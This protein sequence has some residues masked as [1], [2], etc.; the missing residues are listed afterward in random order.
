[1]TNS[2]RLTDLLKRLDG[3]TPNLMA[4]ERQRRKYRKID[5]LF[6][7]TGPLRRELYE[8]Q[9]EFFRAGATCKERAFIAGNRCGKTTAGCY[10]D[11]LHL[12]GE[13]PDCWQGRRF[14]CPTDGWCAGNKK[15]TVRDILQREL[16]GLWGNFGTGLLPKDSIL[17][18][19]RKRGVA[20]AVDTVYVRHA[21]G[22]G[23]N[24]VSLLGFKSYEGRENFQG[25]AK[26]FIHFDEEPSIQ[27]YREALMRT[28]IVPG[29]PAGGLV[30][31]TFTPLRGW[32]DVV[33]EFLSEQPDTKPQNETTTAT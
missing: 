28:M 5:S 29:D 21:S 32:S 26:H 25:T 7:T 18:W 6:P 12:T 11:T 4:A 16:L 23:D 8:K 20:N 2:R 19:T 3:L 1:M 9:L 31:V 17:S 14:A 27:V 30:S 13:Y 10:E 15:L 22:Q 24:A 33:N